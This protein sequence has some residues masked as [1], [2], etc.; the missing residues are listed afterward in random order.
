MAEICATEENKDDNLMVEELSLCC[1]CG[2]TFPFREAL[3][4]HFSSAHKGMT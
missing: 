3:H 2:Q 1:L 4:E